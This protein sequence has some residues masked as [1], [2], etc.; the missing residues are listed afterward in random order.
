M[1]LVCDCLGAHCVSS[2]SAGF[3]HKPRLVFT[4]RTSQSGTW[5]AALSQAVRLVTLAAT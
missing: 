4:T 5:C 2:E 1:Q 3:S